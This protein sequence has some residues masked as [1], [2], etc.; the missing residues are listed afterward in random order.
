MVE[1]FVTNISN[2]I[3]VEGILKMLKNRFPELKINFD[4]DDS[5]TQFPF[6]HT[7]LRVEGSTIDAEK[8]IAT[9]TKS[10]FMCAILEDKICK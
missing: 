7:I 4:L 5:D 3:Q 8:I 1:V 10:G 2:Q 6:C 9:V